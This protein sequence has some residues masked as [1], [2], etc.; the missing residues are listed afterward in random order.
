MKKQWTKFSMIAIAMG[1]IF[2]FISCGK[3]RGFKKDDA[4]YYYKFYVENKDSLQVKD[5][6]LVE[7][8]HT[9]RAVD[10]TFIDNEQMHLLVRASLFEGDL[11]HVLKT[12]H[13]GDS[14][15][16]ILNI[17]TFFHYYFGIEKYNPSS[18]DRDVYLDIKI[19]K[20]IPAAEFQK[21]QEQQ[22]EEERVR[23]EALQQAEDSIMKKYI[24]DNKITVKPT[25]SG[26]YYI[27]KLA[28]KGKQAENGKL[29]TVHYTGKFLDGNV[30]DS[31]I[32]R[33][34]FQLILG[35]GQVIPGWDE[36]IAKMKEGGKAQLLIPSALGYGM[37]GAGGFIP[38]YTPLVFDVELVKVEDAPTN[39]AN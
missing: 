32:G 39:P 19:N 14:A 26:L 28:G 20:I 36:G 15:T 24:S 33:E 37:H 2:I 35:A 7:I 23:M 34:P 22:A 10:S 13:L 18:E 27:Q 6:D 31:S 8:M 30:F 17:D 5:G 12:M 1:A 4:G 29:V 21:L 9:L 11:Y 25:E 3:H 38:P 16:F